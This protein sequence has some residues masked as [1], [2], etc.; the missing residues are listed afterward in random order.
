M[1]SSVIDQYH[2]KDGTLTIVFVS[3]T[4][5]NYLHV[6]QSVYENMKASKSKGIFFNKHIKNKYGFERVD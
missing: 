5:Y 4:V 1:P 6:P 3:G 2:Y